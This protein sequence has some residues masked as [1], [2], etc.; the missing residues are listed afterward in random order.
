MTSLVNFPIIYIT[1]LGTSILVVVV[2]SKFILIAGSK[3]GKN[4]AQVAKSLL[5]GL[6]AW[7]L[8]ALLVGSNVELDFPIL[9]IMI[10]LPLLIGAFTIM[11]PPVSKVL[12]NMPLHFLV[13]L[14]IYRVVGALFL[15]LYYAGS[16]TLSR[17]FALNA[18]WGDLVTGLLALPVAWLIWKRSSYANMALIFWS[19]F[20]I[21]DLILAPMS[22]F[23]FGAEKLVEFPL[24]FVPIFL[25]PPFG[26]LLHLITLRVAWLQNRSLTTKNT[27]KSSS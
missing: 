18:G 14:G 2:L 8:I 16:D 26:I 3:S 1:A 5:I 10:V 11:S 27:N 17:G 25:G 20:G 19:I 22:A 12:L 7:P 15:Y 13:A 6:I 24:N 23:I 9:G 21:A 4:S